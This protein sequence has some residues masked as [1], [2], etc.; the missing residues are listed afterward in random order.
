MTREETLKRRIANKNEQIRD[1]TRL[2]KQRAKTID[3]LIH[4]VASIKSALYEV[5]ASL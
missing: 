1:L 2:C 3:K 5:V 4:R